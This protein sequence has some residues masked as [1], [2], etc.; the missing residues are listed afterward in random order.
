MIQGRGSL[1]QSLLLA[2][3]ITES[4]KTHAQTRIWYVVTQTSNRSS[5]SLAAV[6]TSDISCALEE[7]SILLN[8]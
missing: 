4:Q 2:E 6:R 5:S 7:P 1:T 8:D 3:I